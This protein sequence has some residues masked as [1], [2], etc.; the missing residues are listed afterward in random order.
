[1][2]Q[3]FDAPAKSVRNYSRLLNIPSLLEPSR[4][5]C[6]GAGP[7]SFSQSIRLFLL[8]KLLPHPK[9]V[10]F[11][12]FG[13]GLTRCF[14]HFG[15][16][17]KFLNSLAES[18]KLFGLY[19]SIVSDCP[20]VFSASKRLLKYIKEA[21]LRGVARGRIVKDCPVLKWRLTFHDR[22]THNWSFHM[23]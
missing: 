15:L 1:M 16:S 5:P 17:P 11:R 14:E 21:E 20:I 7:I 10:S 19:A 13:E 23:G 9:H 8:K 6:K 12:T 4:I 2:A 3:A 22:T 18:K